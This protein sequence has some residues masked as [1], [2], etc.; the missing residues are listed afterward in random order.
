MRL[1][2][3]FGANARYF[4]DAAPKIAL[5]IANGD[6]AAG[7]CIDF[8]GRFQSEAA[9]HG[10][11]GFNMPR[12]GSAI[13]ADPIALLR[14]APHRELALGFI[15]FVLSVDGQ[16][17]WDFKIGAPGGP[18]RHA[19]RR[20]PIRPELYSPAYEAFR[21]DP[22][23]RPYEQARSF[24]YTPEWTGPLLRAIAF[25]VRVMC[26]DT[27]DDL[28]RAYRALAEARFPPRATALFDDVRL[29][30]YL[31][32]SG[33]IRATLASRNPVD[34]VVLANELTTALRAQYRQVIDLARSGQ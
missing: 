27:Q 9:P 26:I 11:M 7:M 14:G 24:V 2:R 12:G 13:T 34:E 1:I 28:S 4:S 3:R 23:E 20:L 5:D 30:D 29:V 32:V 16:K 21:S 17:L 22:E 25:I 31:A 15:D 10:R 8:Y 18:E 19:L 33:S 6:A